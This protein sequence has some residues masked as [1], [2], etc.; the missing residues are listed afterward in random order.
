MQSVKDRTFND[1]NTGEMLTESLKLAQVV[2]ALRMECFVKNCV[3]MEV[4]RQ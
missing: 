2:M 1:A 3:Y 4:P